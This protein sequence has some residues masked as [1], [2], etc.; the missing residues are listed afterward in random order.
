MT[1]SERRAALHTYNAKLKAAESSG[2]EA[3]DALKE[4]MG[5][6]P[7]SI[8][9][10]IVRLLQT[11]SSKKEVDH[12]LRHYAS[13]GAGAHNNFA[14]IKVGGGLIRDELDSLVSSLA[15]LVDVGLIPVVIHGAGPQLNAKLEKKGIV[16]EYHGGIRVTTPEIL[17]VAK[18]TFQE[19]NIKL[20]EALENRGVRCRGFAGG[21]FTAEML[22]FNKFGYVGEVTGVETTSIRDQIS[23]GVVPVITCAAEAVSGQLLNVNADVA[24]H[25]LAKALKPVKIIYLSQAGGLRDN[26]GKLMSV[27]D[28]NSQYDSLMKEEWFTHG[29]RLKLKE[30]KTLLDALPMSS[31]VSITSADGLPRELFTHKGSGTLVKR[32]ERIF[33]HTDLKGVDTARLTTLLE[34]SFVGQLA[35]GYFADLKKSLAGLYLS[36]GYTATAIVTDLSSLGGAGKS[37]EGVAYLDKFAVEPAAQG[38]GAAQKLW[39]QLTSRHKAMI[40]RSRKENPINS[41]YFEHSEGSYTAPGS[42]WT[43]FWFGLKDLP[44]AQEAIEKVLAKPSNLA[45]F[46]PIAGAT[47]VGN[48][49][50]RGF[51]T[52]SQ[53]KRSMHTAASGIV[54]RSFSTRAAPKKVRVGIVGARGYTGGEL[55]QLMADHPNL[56]LVSAN[57]RAVVGQSVQTVVPELAAKTNCSWRDLKFG[58]LAP[59][60]LE[61]ARADLWVMALPNGVAKPFVD[62]L[63]A[64]GSSKIIDLSADYRFDSA[65]TYGLPEAKGNRALLAK[66]KQVANPGC[67]ATAMQLALLP[68]LPLLAPGQAPSAFGVS[69]YSGAGTTPSR[70]NDPAALKDNL[71]PYALSGHIHE[72]EVVSQLGLAASRLFGGSMSDL[73]F[74]PHV[75]PWFRGITMTVTATLKEAKT[76]KELLSLFQEYFKDEPLV[77]V[78]N[79]IPEVAAIAG[80]CGAALS[81]HASPTSARPGRVVICATVDNLLKGAA[82]QCLQNINAMHGFEETTAIPKF[83]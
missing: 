33:A 30:I 24:A 18:A 9:Q 53:S 8:K 31:S 48:G 61:S 65:W 73:H 79:E 59:E 20:L 41:W 82:S 38:T 15:F 13:A 49:G 81:V 28:V 46:A 22:D 40:W 78:S 12:Y 21:V 74:V 60:Q 37:L 77:R 62:A 43:V 72:R 4:V 26:T 14:V 1:L 11:L 54:K 68:L 51:A 44:Q 80:T 67:Y 32:T 2:K 39:D 50:S 29:N 25:Q 7:D 76:D 55:I 58:N 35:P 5:A 3:V 52:W 83:K 70:K 36:E 17:Q 19:E 66:A 42:P 6:P 27:I 57:S 23:K 56:E 10:V 47:S 63:Q 69:G 71:M 16:S 75:A 64:S 34:S 45:R